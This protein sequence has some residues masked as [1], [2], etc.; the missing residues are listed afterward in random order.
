MCFDPT[1]CQIVHLDIGCGPGVFS[2]VMHDHMASRNA[3]R[4]DSVVYYGY[5]HCENMIRLARLFLHRFPKRYDFHGYVDFEETVTV[6]TTQDF[7][8]CD[9]VVT[10]GHALLQ[11]QE[12][13]AALE[14]FAGLISCLFPSSSCILVAADAHSRQKRETFRHQCRALEAVLNKFGVRLEDR[15]SPVQ[16]SIMFAR[17]N[18]E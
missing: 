8:D 17:L 18:M 6:L 5:D 4:P 10:F 2:W 1:G 14:E 12:D 11:V 7:A 3:H 15:E 16:G 13:P 9:V